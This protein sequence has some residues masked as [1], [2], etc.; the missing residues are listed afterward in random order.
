MALRNLATTP[1]LCKKIAS[2]GGIPALVALV[3]AGNETI[4]INATVALGKIAFESE[5]RQA[6]VAKAGGIGRVIQAAKSGSTTLKKE[7]M[8]V[9]HN[10]SANAGNRKE[11]AAA[12][13]IPLILEALQPERQI[14]RGSVFTTSLPAAAQAEAKTAI[15]EQASGALRNLV[16]GNAKNQKDIAKMEGV[17]GK[18]LELLSSLVLSGASPKIKANA[19]ATLGNIASVTANRPKIVAAGAGSAL[20]DLLASGDDEGKTEAARA[21]NILDNTAAYSA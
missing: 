2:S 16:I 18:P 8:W 17:S 7:A 21:L 13:G 3:E 20:Q 10:L 1:N 12:G 6:A 14:R 9:L 5:G 4:K 15:M 11:I 19:A